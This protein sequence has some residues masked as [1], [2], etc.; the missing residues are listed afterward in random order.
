MTP[1]SAVLN[2]ASISARLLV[3]EASIPG[4][5]ARGTFWAI[6]LATAVLRVP[7]A[8]IRSEHNYLLNPLHPRFRDILFEVPAE[9]ELDQRLREKK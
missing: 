2:M 5:A 4:T 9:D 8:V 3:A 1:F 7:A 6:S